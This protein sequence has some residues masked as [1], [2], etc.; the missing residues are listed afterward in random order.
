MS[1]ENENLKSNTVCPAAAYNTPNKEGLSESDKK[2]F[3][4]RFDKAS[5]DIQNS[6]RVATAEEIEHWN[7]QW[8]NKTFLPK[9]KE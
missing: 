1:K 6:T 4:S 3:I 5:K 9:E 2:E 8:N 7:T